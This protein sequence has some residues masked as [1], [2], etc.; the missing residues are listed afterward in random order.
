M[1]NGRSRLL[2]MLFAL[3][4]AA[5]NAQQPP[6]PAIP[7]VITAPRNPVNPNGQLIESSNVSK[8]KGLVVP[9]LYSLVRSGKLVMEM[10]PE[11]KYDWDLGEEWRR[12]GISGVSL[13]A[14]G[15]A[16]FTGQAGRGFAFEPAALELEKNAK[17]SGQK[18]LW[19]IQSVFWSQGSV[20]FDFLIRRLQDD[21]PSREL[22]GSFSRVYPREVDRGDKTVQLF[23]ELIEL[24]KPAV[25][26]S[27]TWLTFRF[28][29]PLEDVLWVFSPTI[30]KARELTGANRSDSIAR[31][32]S[33]DD[34]L[35]WSGKAELVEVADVQ[36]VELLTPF[37]SENLVKAYRD[38][39][40]CMAP[41][42]HQESAGDSSGEWNF[43]TQ[44]FVQA[45]AWMPTEVVFVPRSLW[46]LELISK[47]PYSLYGRQ[48]LYVDAETMLP[49]YK[50]V[51]DRAGAHWKSSFIVYGMAEEGK[52]RHP[53]PDKMVMLDKRDD[54]AVLF[55]F[56][57]VKY[58]S[59]LSEELARMRFDPRKLTPPAAA[60]AS[61]KPAGAG[62][63][64]QPARLP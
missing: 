62:R 23:R 28:F 26:S 50:F 14:D 63:P 60:A 22:A 55:D 29:G 61:P 19:N 18:I 64:A 17:I 34:F 42:G 32:L 58:C 36:Q 15:T 39:D 57:N 12:Q 40:E 24:K 5:V 56:M 10:L 16:V 25:L 48:V 6:Q 59:V 38:G 49:I 30:M 51:Y 2:C 35:L 27:Y 1:I 37:R 44:R 8:H 9:E 46:R 52:K 4:P 11:L 31:T 13:D 41:N 53:Y 20:S 21:K 45:A 33:P 7:P 54:S 3:L 47:D 43:Q